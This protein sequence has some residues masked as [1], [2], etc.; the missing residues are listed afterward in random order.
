MAEL[1]EVAHLAQEHG[2]AEVEVGRGRIEAG[3]DHQRLAGRSRALELGAELVLLDQVDGA[4][5]QQRE[6]L[7]DGGKLAGMGRGD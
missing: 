6:L 2:V 4:A 1:L 7:L 3:L 5:A